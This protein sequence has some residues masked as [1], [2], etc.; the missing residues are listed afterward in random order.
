MGL[1]A[2]MLVTAGV[3]GGGWAYMARQHFERAALFNQSLGEAEGLYAEAERIGDDTARWL[4]ARDA[5]RALE[6]LL[7]DARNEST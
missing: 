6:R 1:A 4:I 5:T 3:I 7:T 2:S